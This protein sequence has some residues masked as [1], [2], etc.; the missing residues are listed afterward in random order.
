[1]D[2]DDDNNNNNNNNVNKNKINGGK[3][4]G[5][6]NEAF[7]HT[8]M[9]EAKRKGCI[10]TRMGTKIRHLGNV[11]FY[12]EGIERSCSMCI[13]NELAG[14]KVDVESVVQVIGEIVTTTK[15]DISG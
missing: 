1:M 13:E 15:T 4:N 5:S 3:Y 6:N 14:Y 7:T 10:T 12:D 2:D 9:Y 8:R 11:V